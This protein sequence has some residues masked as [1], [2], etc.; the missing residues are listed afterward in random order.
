MTTKE[1]VKEYNAL[2]AERG[3][4]PLN[5]WKASKEALQAKIDGLHSAQ[6][7]IDPLAID[8]LDTEAAEPLGEAGPDQVPAEA[9]EALGDEHTEPVEAPSAPAKPWTIGAMVKELL[10]DPAGYDYPTIVERVKAE[11]PQA[12]TSKRSIASVAAAL[13][14]DGVEF[15]MRRKPRAKP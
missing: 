8:P 2:A 11:F 7:T 13:R 9:A 12:H 14:R 3:L 1:L 15:P 6:E 10:L 4:P 5:G